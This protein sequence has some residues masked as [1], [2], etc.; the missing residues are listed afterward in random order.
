MT[1]PEITDAAVE[2]ERRFTE[3]FGDGRELSEPLHAYWYALDGKT[4]ELGYTWSD[5]PHRLVFDLLAYAR[6]LERKAAA[7]AA[8]RAEDVAAGWREKLAAMMLRQSLA[9]GHGD[10][11][12]DLLRELEWQ[13]AERAKQYDGLLTTWAESRERHL[14][15]EAKVMRL[16]GTLEYIAAQAKQGYP[17]VLSV[18][19]ANATAAMDDEWQ[20]TVA[21]A[22]ESV[23]WPEV[24]DKLFW[25]AKEF[26]DD[27]KKGDFSLSTLAA[28]DAQSLDDALVRYSEARRSALVSAPAAEAEP[29]SS[30][31]GAPE[32]ERGRMLSRIRELETALP[33]P[34]ASQEALREALERATASL[35]RAVDLAAAM[36]TN[37]PNEPVSDAGHV[38]LDVWKDELERL[39]SQLAA[40]A[41]SP[42]V[43]GGE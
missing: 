40:L 5:K 12:D 11:F 31:W 3:Q 43:Q 6:F 1:S 16:R 15:A 42:P 29:G 21:S 28:L 27:W 24:A 30:F 4:G 13:I 25:S 8:G 23:R 18:I 17:T 20:K 22:L 2:A 9:T 35:R 41:Q 33:A 14:A 26:I 34:S 38:L 36:L 19:H 10:D 39:R 37:D 7:L 32:H